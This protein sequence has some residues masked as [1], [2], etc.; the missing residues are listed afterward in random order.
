MALEEAQPT[1]R[2]TLLDSIATVTETPAADTVTP[3]AQPSEAAVA[4]VPAAESA[5]E[6][7]GRLAGRSRDD[8]GRV[9]PGKPVKT[10]AAQA[11]TPVES[12]LSSAPAAQ[13]APAAAEP[14]LAPIPRPS[15]WKKE[16]WPVW[17]KLV[18]GTPLDAKEARQVAE[19][20]AQRETQFA[21]GVSTYKSV[22][23]AAKPVMDAIAPFKADLDRH[24]IQ[25]PD[26]VHRLMSAHRSLALGSPHE[27]L[28]LFSKLANDYGIPIQALYD[29]NAQQQYLASAPAQAPQPQA[30]QPQDINRLVEQAIVNR[31]VQ[32]TIAQMEANK[33]KY[34]FYPY[35][36][37]TM[38]QLLE[39]NEANDLDDA[40]QKA[41][42]HPEHALLTTVQH[43][44][45]AQAAEAARRATAQATVTAARANT[46]STRSATPAPAAAPTGAKSVRDSILSAVEQVR[47]GVR[48]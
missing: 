21:T 11:Q 25:A 43:S 30:S 32:Q 27:K 47:G 37:A 8:R 35:V 48:V 45:Q 18:A 10:S 16:M 34:P 1:L 6:K 12:V 24:G 26:M 9:L 2:E 19:Y 40:Y 42:E 4:P 22:A 20:N 28:S 14:A 13:P 44:Q 3:A 7:A 5:A 46:V 17:D 33:E 29:Q 36:K 38:A 15:S 41:L 31:E 39:A 23:E